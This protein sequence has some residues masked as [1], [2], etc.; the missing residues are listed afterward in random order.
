MPNKLDEIKCKDKV[1]KVKTYLE[2]VDIAAVAMTSGAGACSQM[3][4]PYIL[5]S[6]E[7]ELT[8]EQIEILKKIGE[9][10]KLDKT[11]EE[12][13]EE[14]MDEDLKK[15][16]D[17]QKKETEAL[18]KKLNDALKLVEK[19]QVEKETLKVE[20][21]ITDFEFEEEMK[22]SIAKFMIKIEEEERGDLIKA[23]AFLKEF[24][25]K[26]EETDTIEDQVTKEKG[27]DAIDENIEKSVNEKITS[28]RNS[29]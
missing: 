20:K 9:Y 22:T 10:S 28:Y 13:K 21:M 3:N 26:K 12:E 27:S 19:E 15:E 11:I 4:D 25:T 6:K 29:K 17:D 14:T 8:E 18:Q 16:L 7:N 24:T 1:K 5:K 2:D 23:F